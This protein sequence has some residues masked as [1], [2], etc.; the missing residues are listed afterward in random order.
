MKSELKW[1]VAQPQ[2]CLKPLANSFLICLVCVSGL[3]PFTSSLF[4]PSSLFV[5]C[6]NVFSL[7]F[8]ILFPFPALVGTKKETEKRTFCLACSYIFNIFLPCRPFPS[9]FLCVCGCKSNF[10]TFR[11]VL[12]LPLRVCVCVCE[13]VWLLPSSLS[14]SP[15]ELPSSTARRC[16]YSCP[17]PCPSPF[18]LLPC[19]LKS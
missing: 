19:C 8:I 3:S 2:T 10:S 9:S 18:F 14:S 7:A 12:C 11:C 13:L 5:W 16:P 6:V 15:L 17:C 1:G 4:C